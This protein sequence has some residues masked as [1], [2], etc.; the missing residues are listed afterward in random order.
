MLGKNIT[1][2]RIFATILF[3]TMGFSQV[4][5]E[6]KNVNTNIDN[7]SCTDSQYSTQSICEAAASCTCPTISDTCEENSSTQETCEIENGTWSPKWIFI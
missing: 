2:S 4:S 6:I 3:I 5:L 7:P 1:F